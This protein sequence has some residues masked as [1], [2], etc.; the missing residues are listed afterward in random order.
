MKRRYRRGETLKLLN[1]NKFTDTIESMFFKLNIQLK[2]IILVF[3][4]KIF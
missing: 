3:K 2:K 4:K 1:M